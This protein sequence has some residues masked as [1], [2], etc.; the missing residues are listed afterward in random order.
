M[1]G[2]VFAGGGEAIYDLK[3]LRDRNVGRVPASIQHKINNVEDFYEDRK[4]S[5]LA[6]A[7]NLINGIATNNQKQPTKGL[8]Q[9]E[10]AIEKYEEQQ[11]IT[12]R[13][14]ATAEKARGGKVVKK[15]RNTLRRTSQASVASRLTRAVANNRGFGER[16]SYAITYMLFTSQEAERM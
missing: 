11:P 14:K 15:A 5:Q 1:C 10:K 2:H 4:N 9:Y 12:E 13:M 6:T 16:K 7:E 3:A 8:K